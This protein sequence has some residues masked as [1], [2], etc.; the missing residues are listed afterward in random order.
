M[1]IGYIDG[2]A[3]VSGDMMLGAL[4]DQ[5]WP[6]EELVGVVERLQLAEVEVQVQKVLRSGI[7]GTK[8]NILVPHTHEHRHLPE[9]KERIASANLPD[10]VK[11]KSLAVFQCLAEAE[12]EVHGVSPNEVHFHEVGAVDAIVDIVGTC[13]GIHSLGLEKI[14]VS[15]LRVGHGVIN[16]QHGYMPVPA[17]ATLN[18][19]KDIPV[20]AGEVKGEWTTPTGAA[21]IRALADEFG[22]LPLVSVTSVG[23]G[24][25]VADPQFPNLLRLIVAEEKNEVLNQEDEVN[26]IETTID[27]M[28]GEYYTY[29]IQQLQLVPVKDYYITPVQMKKNR[30]GQLLTVICDDA[31]V[32]RVINIIFENTSSFGL[33]IRKSSRC[34]LDR[35]LIQLNWQGNNVHIKIGRWREK[36]VQIAPEY[37]D[38]RILAEK[39]GK[40]LDLIYL[41]IKMAAKIMLNKAGGLTD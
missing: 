8:V 34:C 17:P 22:Q 21:L 37:E 33:R 18:L 16:C 41:E 29:L 19:L 23:Y 35:Q 15:P 20:F 38:C 39:L 28:P 36:I 4:V 9:I 10:P 40:P 1:R 24:A 6:L 2:A 31:N 27:D 11:I 30:P 12:G 25:G 3:G 26:V 32:D 14:Y 5:G 13:M 7:G